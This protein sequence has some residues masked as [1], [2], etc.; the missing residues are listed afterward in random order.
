MSEVA[1]GDG[2]SEQQCAANMM[3]LHF[4]PWGPPLATAE[5]LEARVVVS[6]CYV[7]PCY[8]ASVAMWKRPK[9]IWRDREDMADMA[10]YI[11][12]VR[13]PRFGRDGSRNDS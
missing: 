8:P 6:S 2:H 7:P 3:S 10:A 9:W 11:R 12:R 5:G 13:A 4:L 1:G